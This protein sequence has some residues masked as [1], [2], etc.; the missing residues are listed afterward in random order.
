MVQDG[1][2]LVQ[3]D[4]NLLQDDIFYLIGRDVSADLLVA[5]IAL[6]DCQ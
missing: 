2:K 4:K 3:D 5:L 1:E 6:C